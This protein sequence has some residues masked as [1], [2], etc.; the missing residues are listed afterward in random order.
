MDKHAH[1]LGSK[2][3]SRDGQLPSKFYGA[4]TEAGSNG[5]IAARIFFGIDEH[6]P[7]KDDKDALDELSMHYL[8][9]LAKG[10]RVSLS[11]V[12]RADETYH[13][14]HNQRLSEDRARAVLVYVQNKMKD[15]FVRNKMGGTH[16]FRLQKGRNSQSCFDTRGRVPFTLRPTARAFP[17]QTVIRNLRLPISPR[18]IGPA[19]PMMRA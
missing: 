15:H 9:E 7:G 14:I 1:H 18:I 4:K 13:E 3:C 6:V 17:S 10:S 5:Q 2:L 16:S 19:S 12:D 8:R 11:F